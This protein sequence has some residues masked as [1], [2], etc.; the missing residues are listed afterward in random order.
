VPSKVIPHLITTK[1]TEADNWGWGYWVCSKKPTEREIFD[2]DFAGKAY[3]LT[4]PG[5]GHLIA[6]I[7]TENVILTL[8]PEAFT[9]FKSHVKH[10]GLRCNFFQAITHTHIYTNF[11]IAIY[12]HNTHTNSIFVKTPEFT[13]I[14]YTNRNFAI[15]TGFCPI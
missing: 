1:N 9:G 2:R 15:F 8:T 12:T 14:C 10:P 3:K 11:K 4:T 6:F 5:Q 7:C 13:Q